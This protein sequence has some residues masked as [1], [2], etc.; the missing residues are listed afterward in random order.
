MLAVAILTVTAAIAPAAGG[1]LGIQMEQAD[2]GI[3]ITRIVA[4]G[5]ADKA[6]MQAGDIVNQIGEQPVK[7]PAELSAKIKGASPGDTVKFKILRAE[8]EQ[9]LEVKLGKRPAAPKREGLKNVRAPEI[10]IK[11]WHQL[12]KGKTQLKL[13]DFKDKTVFLYCFQS[14]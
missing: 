3:L 7:S 6:G 14:W 12:P 8:K 13:A 1:F 4:D 2:Q 9:Q 5:P 10:E 11:Q